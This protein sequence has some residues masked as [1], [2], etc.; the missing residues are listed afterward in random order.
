LQ[1]IGNCFGT[2]VYQVSSNAGEVALLI[3]VT[4]IVGL[5]QR[6]LVIAGSFANFLSKSN[7]A[8]VVAT[9]FDL[10][11]LP[12]ADSPPR[13][14]AARAYAEVGQDREQ[15][16]KTLQIVVPMNMGGEEEQRVANLA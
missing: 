4:F 7:K 16:E 15:D 13:G 3:G 9:T 8:F 12:G 2:S 10:H 14:A 1:G 11:A 5:V 6:D